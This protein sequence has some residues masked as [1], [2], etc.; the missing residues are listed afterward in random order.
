MRTK[1][2][3]EVSATKAGFRKGIVTRDH[4][5]NLRMIIQK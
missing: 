3:E 5:F 4:N 2:E 1:L